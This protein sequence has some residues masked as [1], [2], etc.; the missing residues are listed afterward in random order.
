MTENYSKSILELLYLSNNYKELRNICEN[1]S[2]ST[3]LRGYA[4]GLLCRP[5]LP[6]GKVRKVILVLIVV[7]S[8][9]LSLTFNTPYF[10][11]L[12]L[13]AASLSPRLVGEVTYLMGNLFRR[14][15]L[16]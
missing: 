15:F 1:S 11:F 14:A 13:I 4:A 9:L 12:L 2:V 5:W 8:L 6:W 10:L 3:E 16:L 7:M